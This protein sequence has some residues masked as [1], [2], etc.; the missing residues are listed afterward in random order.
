M[1]DRILLDRDGP[2]AI[3]TLSNPA[4]RNAFTPDMRRAITARLQELFLD[5]ACRAIIL[6]GE[7]GHFCAGA[8]LSR[9]DPAA[10]RPTALATRENMKEVH[11]LLKALHAGPKPVI[12]AVEGL[13]YGGGLSMALA[14]D[15]IVAAKS[16]RFGAAFSKLA[17]LG[18]MGILYTLKQRVG[19][20]AAKHILAL[21]PQITGEEAVQMRLADELA[22]E[23]GALTA[24]LAVARTYAEMAAPLSLAYTKAAYANGI[25]RIEDAFQAELDYLPLVIASKDFQEA[26]SAFKEKRAPVFS[27]A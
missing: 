11:Q 27:G 10:P 19:L 5:N 8:D 26:L 23:G 22:E 18:D 7:N 12:A 25:D 2:V 17:I 9:V 14:C 16:A 1:T 15:R 20:A 21:G 4:R 3:I 24:A 13:A 6:T